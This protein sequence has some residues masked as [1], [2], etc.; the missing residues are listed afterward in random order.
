MATPAD[1]AQ[2][3]SELNKLTKDKLISIIIH[4]KI[5]DGCVVGD[6]V[7]NFLRKSDADE[8]GEVFQDS[9]S[10]LNKQQHCDKV[11]CIN[12]MA[13]L[14][15][16]RVEVGAANRIIQE[17]E[18]SVQNLNTIIELLKSQRESEVNTQTT[19]TST[20]KNVNKTR[21]SSN[22][23]GYGTVEGPEQR[24]PTL[25]APTASNSLRNASAKVTNTGE[26][27]RG[28]S[29]PSDHQYSANAQHSVTGPAVPAHLH[30]RLEI[31]EVS[32][33]ITDAK[34]I[35]N[36]Q[37]E[38]CD[39]KDGFTQVNHKRR[40]SRK[41]NTIIG[42]SSQDSTLKE[43]VKLA[44]LHVYKL[45]PETTVSELT[46]FLKP[47]FPEVQVEQLTSRYP[48]Y[49]ASFKVTISENKLSAALTP[50]LWPKGV[51]INRFFHRK[52]A[53]ETVA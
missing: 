30:T 46:D 44:F 53:K 18:K 8:V 51:C 14:R 7:G 48:K 17:Q 10:S 43:P 22:T 6:V 45:H 28:R 27:V 21:P 11:R 38:R 12:A 35:L 39:D 16:A 33:A 42:C 15:I 32:R 34:Q 2:I 5:P 1:V 37:G 50:T 13:D 52:V 9:L 19:N 3:S 47:V 36:I 49:Y 23:R 24:R 20:S 31:G 40:R 41:Q 26:I 29:D 4:K 25:R